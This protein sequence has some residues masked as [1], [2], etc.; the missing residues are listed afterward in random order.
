MKCTTIIGRREDE[1][2]IIYVREKN[3]IVEEI[4]ALC[5]ERYENILGYAGDEIVRL[6]PDDVEA[7]TVREGKVYALS[8]GRD[9]LVKERLYGFEGRLSGFVK[10]NQSCLVNLR[11]IKS[12]RTSFGGS[13]S[14]HL[15][16]GYTDYVS[17]RQLKAVKE[18]VGM[19]KMRKEE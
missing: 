6:T 5:R 2:V 1:E 3:R 15:C 18:A 12:F 9:F 14:V 13:L 17:R 10:I 4:E 7:I 16:S 8:G 11:H 19:R